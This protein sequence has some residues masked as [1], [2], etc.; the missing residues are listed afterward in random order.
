[1]PRSKS[2]ID[3]FGR[4]GGEDLGTLGIG[5][6]VER[7]LV[8]VLDEVRPLGVGRQRGQLAERIGHRDSVATDERQVERLVDGEAEEHVHLVAVLA[9]E[10]GELVERLVRLRQQHGVAPTARH[11]VAQVTQVAVRI[12]RRGVS[13]STCSIRN[14]TASTRNPDRPSSS[15]KPMTLW[16]SLRTSGLLTFR[17]GWCG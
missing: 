14:G 13:G 16:I 6:L 11:E 12:R 15:Q 3:L 2:C 8:V 1:M 10:L 17:S 7:C 5:Q 4:E 9:E